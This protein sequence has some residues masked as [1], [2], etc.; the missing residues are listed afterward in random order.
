MPREVQYK[1]NLID[2]DLFV[3]ADKLIFNVAK[4]SASTSRRAGNG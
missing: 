1:T 3:N 2:I 4:D